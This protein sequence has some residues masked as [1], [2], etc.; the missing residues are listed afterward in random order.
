MCCLYPVAFAV[1]VQ[2]YDPYQV[3]NWIP[4]RNSPVLALQLVS[5]DVPFVV[6]TLDGLAQ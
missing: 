5:G 4:S 6:K 2:Q 3:A 1:S